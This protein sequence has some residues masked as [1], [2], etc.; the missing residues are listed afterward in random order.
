MP[1][2][3]LMTGASDLASLERVLPQVLSALQ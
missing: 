2:L 3:D 1:Y